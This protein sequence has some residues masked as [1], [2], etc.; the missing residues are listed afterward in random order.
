MSQCVRIGNNPMSSIFFSKLSFQEQ[1]LVAFHNTDIREISR[2]MQMS[3]G[4]TRFVIWGIQKSQN[5]SL[6]V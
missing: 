3:D 1:L 5:Q 2:L 4:F 6:S